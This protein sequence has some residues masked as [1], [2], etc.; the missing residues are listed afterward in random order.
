MSDQLQVAAA[1]RRMSD[2]ALVEL[3]KVRL[4]NTTYLRDF[5]DFADA[6]TAAKSATSAIASLS[7][8]QLDALEA[9]L[10]GKKADVKVAN[11]LA[12]LAL[13]EKT[14]T[15]FVAFEYATNCY[16]E[17]SSGKTAPKLA[18]VKFTSELAAS[19]VDRDAHLAIFD[20]I[21]A[22]TELVFD[23]EQRYIRE[24]G[25]RGVGLPDIKRL[26]NHLRKPNDYAKQVFEVALWS[27][28]AVISNSRWQLGPQYD[29]WLQWT[30]GKRWSH[31]AGIWL[32]IL[33][34]AGARELNGLRAGESLFDA[35]QA[36][37]RLADLT[38]N[39]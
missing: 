39:S 21:Q 10:E 15:A 29:N 11:E 36:S 3:A 22:L 18:S 27:N 31:L 16:R 26:A 32:E 6:L 14:T 33:G 35:L 24:V 34:D 30:D 1:L 19:D 25:K 12:S 28:L 37:Y 8:R 7:N 23:L 2:P 13:V 38:V 17:L 9:I 4:V 5:F 20:V